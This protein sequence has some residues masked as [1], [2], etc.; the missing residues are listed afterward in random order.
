[1]SC[2][3]ASVV[4]ISSP[5]IRRASMRSF[6]MSVTR[7]AWMAARMAS[8][9]RLTMYISDACCSASTAS[10][11]NRTSAQQINQ[12]KPTCAS[13]QHHERTCFCNNECGCAC[14]SSQ[15]GTHTYRHTHRHTQTQTHKLTCFEVGC[16][17]DTE[18]TKRCFW[19]QVFCGLLVLFDFLQRLLSRAVALSHSYEGSNERKKEEAKGRRMESGRHHTDT[20]IKLTRFLRVRTAAERRR[21]EDRRADSDFGC[22]L[23]AT[24]PRADLRAVCFKRAITKQNNKQKSAARRTRRTRSRKRLNYW[25]CG[26]NGKAC[27]LAEASQLLLLGVAFGIW[28]LSAPKHCNAVRHISTKPPATHENIAAALE[29]EAITSLEGRSEEGIIK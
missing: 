24:F 11:R 9:K 25:V 3:C 1:M 16:K 17:G 20:R 8:S 27:S 29:M 7:R 10:T 21:F 28:G 4:P 26:G 22:V 15:T 14:V 12:T 13:G 5:R 23:T 2:S 19:N 18:P 6:G